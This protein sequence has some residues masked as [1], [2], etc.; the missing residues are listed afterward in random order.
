MVRGAKSIIPTFP[1]C[2]RKETNMNA[3]IHRKPRKWDPG[4]WLEI[5]KT[6]VGA[7]LTQRWERIWGLE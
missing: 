5:Q 2:V 7:M 4:G 1:Q 3:L 6:V